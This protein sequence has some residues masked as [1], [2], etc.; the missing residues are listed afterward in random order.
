MC[1]I[2]RRHGSVEVFWG[3][4][5]CVTKAE[6]KRL[7]KIQMLTEVIMHCGISEYEDSDNAVDH[8]RVIQ[9]AARRAWEELNEL[10]RNAF[11][12]GTK[13]VLDPKENE[14]HLLSAEE[15]KRWSSRRGGGGGGGRRGRGRGRGQRANRQPTFFTSN[16]QDSGNHH[17]RA[18]SPQHGRGGGRY[19]RRRSA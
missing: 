16:V 1:I 4:S 13:G 12:R 15:E 2:A 9:A 5:E 14:D 6:D 19:Q 11:V 18:H 17:Q 10:R 3:F 8:A 7:Q